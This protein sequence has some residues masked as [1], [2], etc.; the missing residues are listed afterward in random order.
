M[1]VD[2]SV[3]LIPDRHKAGIVSFKMSLWDV[4]KLGEIDFADKKRYKYWNTRVPRRS[5]PVRVRAYVY[6]CRD[7][8]AADAEG[9]SDP[10]IQ[11]WD[12][13]ET[14]VKT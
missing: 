14:P 10:F 7:L 4:G 13:S 3:G 1:R 11:A 5:N 6:S 8:P 9:T 2:E 12:T